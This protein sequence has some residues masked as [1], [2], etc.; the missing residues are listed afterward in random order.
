MQPT[1]TK[2]CLSLA[3]ICCAASLSAQKIGYLQSEKTGA[4]RHLSVQG[5]TRSMNW[6]LET[7]GSQYQWV[8]EKYGWGLGFC[9]VI[10]GGDTVLYEWERPTSMKD[11]TSIYKYR[12]V[13]ISVVRRMDKDDLV[14][15]YRFSNTGSE[16]VQLMDVG[17]YTPFNDNYPDAS[18]CYR[19]RTNAHIWEGENDAYVNAMHMSGEGPHLGLVVVEG[20]VKSYEVKERDRQKAMSNT[21]GVIAL[22]PEDM[23]LQAGGNY[24]LSWRIFAHRGEDD[25]FAKVLKAGATIGRSDKYVYQVGD[26]AKV[27]FESLKQLKN[28]RI[29]V[30]GSSLPVSQKGYIYTA[31]T[32]V[33]Q[34]GDIRFDLMYGDRKTHVS[35][36]GISSEQELIKKRA[37]FIISHQQLNKEDDKRN[38]AYLVYDNE[39]DK[40]FLNDSPSVSPYDRDEGAERLG[41]GVFLALYYHKTKDETVKQSLLRYARFVR[42]LQDENYST[43]SD[44]NHKSRDR[45]YNYP[46]IADFYF[47]MFQITGDRKFLLEGYD[48]LRAMYRRF[49]YGFYAI[50]I[51]IWQS[52]MLLRENQMENEADSLLVGFKKTGDIYLKNGVIY[53]QHEV[54]YEQSIVA[55]SI[56]ALL[57]LYLVTG[58]KKYLYGAEKQLPLLESFGGNQPSYHLNNISIRHWDGYWF[59]KREKWGDTMP[60]YWSTLS[61][62]AYDLYS[63]CAGNVSYKRRAAHIVRNNLC[64]FFED[65]KA[66]CAYIY[67]YKVNGQRAQFYDPYANDQDWALVYYL[68][69]I[70]E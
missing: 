38:G 42:T 27:S 12:Y 63:Q 45:A 53:P 35:C 67:P 62:V 51:P 68:T 11:G 64:L 52:I 59:G 61:A 9:S 65:G 39:T 30:N 20:A 43:W 44:I 33:N 2:L 26:T 70:S 58:E 47:Q 48:T 6:M 3:V 17:I 21:R 69:F 36:L 50:G 57:Q 24:V 18:V 55:P 13:T 29:L 19:A 8:G 16:Q 5:D 25:F 22:N 56:I 4:I 23:V 32:T 46:W 7:D 49:G 54:N 31:S 28:P 34:T 15:E 41:M 14:E 1:T 10:S 66:S 40:I 60:H 37:D